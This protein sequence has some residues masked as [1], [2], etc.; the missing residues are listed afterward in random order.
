MDKDNAITLP[1]AAAGFERF[2]LRRGGI[3]HVAE[4]QVLAKHEG[5]FLVRHGAWDKVMKRA[6][7][8]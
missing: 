2:A 8:K 1:R 3:G 4:M 5:H 7:E 6:A